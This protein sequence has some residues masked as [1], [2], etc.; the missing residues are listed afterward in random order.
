MMNRA[1][2]PP[3]P[4]PPPGDGG[5]A[6]PPGAAAGAAA[7]PPG[8]AAGAAAAAAAG[9]APPAAAAQFLA[10]QPADLQF[11]ANMMRGPS[12]KMRRMTNATPEA[13][14]EYKRHFQKI[15]ALQNWNDE[16][17]RQELAAGVQEKAGNAVADIDIYA[18]GVDI[19]DIIEAY[20]NRFLPAAAGATARTNYSTSR[21]IPTENAREW[22]TKMRE[23]F[24]L[25][26]PDLNID[27][28]PHAMD[29][30]IKGLCNPQVHFF[31]ASQHIENFSACLPVAERAETA[32]KH[33]PG[34]LKSSINAM[35]TR[36]TNAQ[37]NSLAPPGSGNCYFC[38]D[39]FKVQNR[40]LKSN[41]PYFKAANKLFQAHKRNK[42]NPNQA[43]A[44]QNSN[45]SSTNKNKPRKKKPNR[46]VNAISDADD[47]ADAESYY[48]DDESETPG[49]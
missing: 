14:L 47:E 2:A 24:C 44:S 12:T 40:H 15:R 28:T 18:P 10:M 45:V 30:Y 21:Q 9:A 48:S 16:R 35:Q 32:L 36:S 13:W 17:C 26:Y 23:L 1:P 27:E 6:V 49:N 46:N 34:G 4:P 33:S 5:A 37:S 20:Q 39:V 43:P 3:P 42:Q 19:D 29:T 31:V 22:H 38:A 25:A 41:C 11:L 8:A 7:V